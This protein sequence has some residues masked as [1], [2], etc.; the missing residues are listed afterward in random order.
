MY[1][2]VDYAVGIARP[3][4]HDDRSFLKSRLSGLQYFTGLSWILDPEV[5]QVCISM[6]GRA[7]F[8]R[9]SFVDVH[10]VAQNEQVSMIR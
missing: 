10:L 7:Q 9:L 4:S 6:W 5:Q 8:Y 2:F 1:M 3:A